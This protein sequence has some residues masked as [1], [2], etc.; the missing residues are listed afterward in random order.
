MEFNI[1]QVSRDKILEMVKEEQKV[2]YSKGIQ[3]AY[4]EQYYAMKD[5]N[6]ER[7]NIEQQI[8]KFI[9]QEQA[10]TTFS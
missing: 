1:N 9:F 8:Q 7:V 6:Y 10:Y 5:V 4:T 3:E 2:R